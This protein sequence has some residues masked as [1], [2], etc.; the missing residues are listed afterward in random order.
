MCHAQLAS[1]LRIPPTNFSPEA[2]RCE[3][4]KVAHP[5]REV[6]YEQSFPSSRNEWNVLQICK[7]NQQSKVLFPENPHSQFPFS[8]R[9]PLRVRLSVRQSAPRKAEDVLTYPQLF[10]RRRQSGTNHSAVL[11]FVGI[12]RT[13]SICRYIPPPQQRPSSVTK[14]LPNTSNIVPRNTSPS[15]HRSMV[16][17]MKITKGREVAADTKKAS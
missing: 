9:T 11:L 7:W 6:K 13:T 4:P 14:R 16:R 10:G 3:Q 1:V 2:N 5:Q 8:P 17:A 12:V 15:G